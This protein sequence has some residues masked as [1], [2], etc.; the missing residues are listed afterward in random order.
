MKKLLTALSI[1]LIA[2]ASYAQTYTVE[3]VIDGDTIM[4]GFT[5][6]QVEKV[7]L[8]DDFIQKQKIYFRK[9]KNKIKTIINARKEQKEKVKQIKRVMKENRAKTKEIQAKIKGSEII[10]QRIHHQ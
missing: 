8:V 7:N 3:R 1:L 9:V 4:L 10:G 2:T 6:A 5:Q